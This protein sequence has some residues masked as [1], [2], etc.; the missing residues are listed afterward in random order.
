[1]MSRNFLRR[2]TFICLMVLGLFAGAGAVIA[3]PLARP[4][5]TDRVVGTAE[6]PTI[7]ACIDLAKAG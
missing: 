5:Q 2:F 4:L 3:T 6:C 7:Q 1:M